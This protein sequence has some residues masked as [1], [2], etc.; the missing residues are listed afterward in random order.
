MA[1]QSTRRRVEFNRG[2]VAHGILGRMKKPPDT[3]P[4][5]QAFE[6]DLP[7]LDDPLRLANLQG[8]SEEV[9][10]DFLAL[11]NGQFS[12]A[13][14]RDK[15]L[16]TRAILDLDM[17]GFTQMSIQEG[18]I[19]S[20]LRIFDTQKVAIPVLEKHKAILTRAFADDLV[21]LFED[22]NHA[23]DAALQIHHAVARSNKARGI[24]S[25]T[26]CCIGIGFGQ[27]YAIGPNLAQGREMN[28]A[29]KLGE[30][31]AR[32]GETLVTEQA[33]AALADRDD[34]CFERQIHDDL[35]VVFYKA[36]P[37]RAD[38]SSG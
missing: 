5:P 15:Y 36:M 6:G 17:T 2:L 1:A 9:Y 14:F 25:P 21:A 34:I 28:L 32:G 18:Q 33:H 38:D 20:L 26:E 37:R 3:L 13:A 19:E 12:K 23:F 16:V 4:E 11:Q 8:W 24:K 7:I 35:N 22:V 30:D 31:I 27:V 10:S 29:S